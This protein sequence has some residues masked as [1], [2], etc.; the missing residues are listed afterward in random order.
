M[1]HTKKILSFV[2]ALCVLCTGM[3]YAESYEVEWFTTPFPFYLSDQDMPAGTYIVSRATIGN[4]LR[5]QNADE[6]HSAFV[7]YNPTQS[8]RP[9]PQGKVTFYKYG[10]AYYLSSLTQ[11]GEELGMEVL[12]S[13]AEKRA[14]MGTREK[15]STKSV[16]LQPVVPGSE[17]ADIS[18]AGSA[19]EGR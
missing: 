3:L 5:I 11:T 13:K 17:R 10:E 7:L 12:K 4:V 15:P 1:T 18:A 9:A 19:A 6:P 8:T 16:A 14:A 2:A